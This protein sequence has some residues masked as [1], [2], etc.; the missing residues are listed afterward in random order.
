MAVMSY[1]ERMAQLQTLK[2]HARNMRSESVKAKAI[3]DYLQEAAEDIEIMAYADVDLNMSQAA[4]DVLA[5]RKRQITA[6]GWTPE[7]DDGH[8][9]LDNGRKLTELARAAKAYIEGDSYNW[10][11]HVSSFKPSDT[12]RNLVRAGALILAEIDRLDRAS[13]KEPT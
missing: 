5:E 4:Q 1:K 7:H 10:P 2:V 8:T 6:E 13:E 9:E 11:W 12:R 3:F